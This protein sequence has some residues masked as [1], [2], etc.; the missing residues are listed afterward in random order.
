MV[1]ESPLK[2][3]FMNFKLLIL[4]TLI[5]I[6]ST[7]TQAQNNVK[8]IPVWPDGPSESNG[9]TEQERTLNNV[10]AFG[11]TLH[12]IIENIAEATFSVYSPS[13]EKNTGL[14]V[15]ICP[16]GAY[17][18]E[19]FES[20]GTLLATWLAE[21][22]ITGVVLKY[23]LPNG[24][25]EIPLKDAQQ[26]IRILRKDAG[27]WGINPN[28]IGI[29]GF[30]A[31]GHL[32]SMVLTRAD[33][34]AKANFAVLFYPLINIAGTH[35]AYQGL[36]KIMLGVNAESENSITKYSTHL[37][38]GKETAPTLLLHSNDDPAVSAQN[39]VSFYRALADHGISASL[40]IFPTG[41]HGW[42]FEKDF[43]YHE[44]LKPIVLDWIL[45]QQ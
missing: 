45:S 30:S 17:K 11:K 16:G 19:S 40:H 25:L 38:V 37:H 33:E 6:I 14:T 5:L 24:N 39:S 28:K 2:S 13:A 18:I 8:N 4:S 22:G 7:M 43:K 21:N 20:E 42:G 15:V 3:A 35:E 10:P 34:S 26:T 44:Q 31:G 29:A 9:I 1:V 23:R 41:G 12:G 32:A 36:R 27:K